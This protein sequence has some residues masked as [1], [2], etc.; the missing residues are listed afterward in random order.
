MMGIRNRAAIKSA[1]RARQGTRKDFIET[2]TKI[3]QIPAE[4]IVYNAESSPASTTAPVLAALCGPY[5]LARLSPEGR[6]QPP[7]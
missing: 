7:A 5:L 1:K 6:R 2:E 4:H 3:Y